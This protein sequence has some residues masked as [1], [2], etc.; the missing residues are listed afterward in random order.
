MCGI[1]AYVGQKEAS[2]IVLSALRRLEYR[3]YD[4]AGIA[5]FELNSVSKKKSHILRCEG[6]IDQLASLLEKSPVSGTTALGHTRWATHG[7]PSERN[8]HPHR[9]QDVVIV[10]NG[11]IE[12]YRELRKHLS[13]SGNKFKSETDSEVIAHLLQE[14]LEESGSFEKS[15]KKLVSKLEGAF[16]LA[17]VWI[18]QPETL[19]VAK[20]HSPL[21]LGKGNGENFV[22]SD[23]PALLEY[24]QEFYILK[25]EEMA[26]IEADRVRLFDFKGRKL[27]RKTQKVNWSLATAEKEGYEH[28]ML[29]EIHEQ[30]RVLQDTLRGR[31]LKGFKKVEF[32]GVKWKSRD[33]KAIKG[34]SIVACGTAWHAGLLGK[35]WVEK[36]AKLPTE[37]DLASEF[38]YRDPILA[39]GSVALAISQSGETAD[40]LAAVSE[41]KR[42]K[43]KLLSITNTVESSVVRATKNVIYTQAGPEIS[44]ASTKCFL[45]QLEALCLFAVKLGMERKTLSEKWSTQFLKDLSGLGAKIEEVLKLEDQISKIASNYKDYGNY[46]YLGRGLSYPIALEGALKLKEIAYINTQSYPAGEMK[47]GPIALI[48]EDWP[49]V[50]IAPKDSIRGKIIS[51]IEAVKARGGKIIT[52]GTSGDKELKSLSNEFI[53]IPEVREELTPFLTVVVLQLF[54]YHCS[55]LL[56]CDVD[57]PKNLAKSVTVE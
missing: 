54:A 49:V 36:L 42:K 8:A 26:F 15:C 31:V 33:W 7:K 12:N 30:P 25:D 6:R 19:F 55:R 51:N 28:F 21:L 17:A 45:A 48:S 27:E 20:Q 32:E 16:A 10:H 34:L 39:K 37:V 35:Y 9:H 11:I 1:V 56:G 3:G 52:V 40:T 24:T 57:K 44:V 41:A 53:G 13:K 2:P 50:C 18:K 23:I 22:A 14:Y 29:K 38:R 43:A 4:S 46:F 47:H 5:G